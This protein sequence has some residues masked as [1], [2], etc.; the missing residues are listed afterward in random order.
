MLIAE[1]DAYIRG[2]MNLSAFEKIDSS[3][4]GLQVARENQEIGKIAFALDACLAVFNRAA[5]GKA[6]FLFVHHGL[7]WG[8]EQPITGVA[9]GRIRTLIE[10]GLALYAVHLPLDANPEFGNNAMLAKKLML[11]DIEPFGMYKGLSIGFKGRLPSPMG[12][13]EVTALLGREERQTFTLLPFGKKE[14]RTVGVIAGGA[15][16]EVEQAIAE[17]LDLYVTGEAG[18]TMYHL[19]QEAGI[20]VIA[21]G[22][23]LTEK[24]GMEAFMARTAAD[25][26]LETMFID[27][28]TGL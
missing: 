17:G 11:T 2:L 5:Q 16:R 12:F 24:W 8:K 26:D 1:F 23:Y 13:E 14:I 25:T 21:G 6:D 9:F 20:H 27:I 19:C 4:N 3:L 15:A 7:F 22:H 28:P 18:H 10:T